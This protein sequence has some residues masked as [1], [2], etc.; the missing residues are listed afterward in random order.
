[1][2]KFAEKEEI[3]VF[4]KEVEYVERPPKRNCRGEKKTEGETSSASPFNEQVIPTLA[5]SVKSRRKEKE[6]KSDHAE[7]AS[8]EP[9]DKSP[10]SPLHHESK[11]NKRKTPKEEIVT[12]PTK[13]EVKE[14]RSPMKSEPKKRKS[15]E[16]EKDISN[17]KNESKKSNELNEIKKTLDLLDEPKRKRSSGDK[18]DLKKA[19]EMK[20]S[21]IEL[22]EGSSDSGKQKI[23]VK[24]E[25]D[26][27]SNIE[28]KK[29]KKD[30]EKPHESKL[31]KH[32][33][34]EKKT[35]RS[36][37]KK[38][39]KFAE[40]EEIKV[41]EK[42]VEYVERPPKRNCRGE[43]KTEGETSSASPFNDQVIPTLA[44][45][46]KSRRKEK[47]KKSDHAEQASPE[48]LDKS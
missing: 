19:I 24:V 40:K 30:V 25:D 20:K 42:E 26:V 3:K 33:N 1:M 14:H 11:K 7:Q 2:G 48:P 41:F 39:V 36:E 5:D 37:E 46:V 44:D 28:S 8:P 22:H 10:I 38:K 13:T 34:D 43:K 45:S 12:S 6:K 17:D 29:E 27:H 21:S 32:T 15:I 31:K 9:L 4:E 16:K 47:E 18:H 35:P 23:S